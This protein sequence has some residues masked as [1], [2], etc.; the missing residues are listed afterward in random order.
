MPYAT[1]MSETY[2]VGDFNLVL[3][4]AVAEADPQDFHRVVIGQGPGRLRGVGI[5]YY[6]ES[7]LGDP[8]ETARW[9]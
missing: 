2:D 7:I 1:T 3:D 4:R 8:S 9:S 5:C 6:I